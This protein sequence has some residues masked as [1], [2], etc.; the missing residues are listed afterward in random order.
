MHCGSLGCPG[1]G[2]PVFAADKDSC[3][4]NRYAGSLSSTLR[5][6]LVPSSSFQPPFLRHFSRDMPFQTD[7]TWPP[8]LLSI[9]GT[10]PRQTR[11]IRE[12]LFWSLRQTV[13]LLFRERFRILRRT[14]EF[15]VLDSHDAINFTVMLVVSNRHV[16]PVLLIEV[17]ELRF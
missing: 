6:L 9:F 4:E 15:P 16:K 2:V 7:N 13:E 3:R 17:A 14:A 11:D 8:G 1:P 5:P 10:L 12:L